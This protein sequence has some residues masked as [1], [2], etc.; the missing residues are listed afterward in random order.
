MR[1]GYL[2]TRALYSGSVKGP[3]WFTNGVNWRAYVA[4]VLG[5]LINFV[6]FIG[7]CGVKVPEAALK[8]YQLNFFLGIIVAGVSYW[9]LCKWSP[10]PA[11]GDK[12]CSEV[13]PDIVQ[14]QLASYDDDF[15]DKMSLENEYKKGGQTA[16][17]AHDISL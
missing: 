12:W 8:M 1:K 2:D 16:F 17:A 13:D 5:I 4:Y 10:I 11:C 9:L 6:G 14:G 3:Y 7:Q 15:T